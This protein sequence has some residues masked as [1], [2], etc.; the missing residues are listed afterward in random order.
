MG[1]PDYSTAWDMAQAAVK[2]FDGSQPLLKHQKLAIDRWNRSTRWSLDSADPRHLSAHQ[3]REVSNIFSDIFFLQELGT[4]SVLEIRWEALDDEYGVCCEYDNDAWP[5]QRTKK[6]ILLNEN[7]E[8]LY[9]DTNFTLC[10]LMHEMA[11]A[12]LK[13]DLGSTAENFSD[14]R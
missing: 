6:V 7:D 11:H 14:P 9:R 4:E 3:L 13:D 8:S 12:F 5:V 1:P 2:S 10:V